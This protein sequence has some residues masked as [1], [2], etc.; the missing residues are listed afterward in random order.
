MFSG[1][2][3]VHF[4]SPNPLVSPRV[5]TQLKQYY[6]YYHPITC[7]SMWCEIEMVARERKKDVAT[8]IYMG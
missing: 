5:L 2:P 7:A 1:E 8:Q 3:F 6:Y 4:L